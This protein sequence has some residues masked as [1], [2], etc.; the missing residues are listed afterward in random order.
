MK[1]ENDWS[2]ESE[3]RNKK[4]ISSTSLWDGKS[5]DRWIFEG[6]G[7]YSIE[8]NGVMKLHTYARSDHWPESEVRS[9][10]EA[11]GK[12]TTFGS[13]I[14]HL[15]VSSL[16]LTKGNRISF[17]IRPDCEGAHSTIVRVG[18]VNDGMIKIPDPYARE[19][20]NAMNLKNHEWNTCTW[21]IDSIA[22]D[23][24]T[25]ISFNCHRYGKE[26]SGGDNLY[27][28]IKDIC[29]D[30]VKPAVVHGWQCEGGTVSY[31]TSGYTASG[32]KTAVV[33]TSTETFSLVSEADGKTVYTGKVQNKELPAGK[34]QYIDFSDFCKEGTY[35]LQVGDFKT[36]PF[37]ISGNVFESSL[38]KMIN[39]LYSERCGYPVPN[40]H[41]T[42]HLDVTAEHNGKRILFAGGWHDAA[43]VSQQTVQTAEVCEGLM[44]AAQAVKGKNK[45]L[46]LRLLEEANYGL[47]FVLRSRFGD[48][49]RAANCSI[50]RWTNLET[51]DMDDETASVNNRSFENFIFAA[52]EA[53]AADAFSERDP[54]LCFKLRQTAAEDF[55]FAKERLVSYGL[56]DFLVEQHTSSASISQYYAA[57]ALAAARLVKIGEKSFD[58]DAVHFA[59]LVC[60]CQ[61]TDESREFYG[62]FYRDEKKECIVHFTHQA[63][64]QIFAQALTEVCGVI[65]DTNALKR[66]DK[67]IRLHAAYFKKLFSYSTPYGMLPSGIYHISELDREEDFIRI[68][69]HVVFEEEKENYRKQ[70]QNGIKLGNGYYLRM[71]PVW[72]SF[73]GNN[74]VVLSMGKAASALG[75]YLKD[76]ELLD[77]G[78]EQLYWVL[79][80]NPFRQSLIFGEGSR[81][82]RNYTALLC[83]TTGEIPVGVQT[84]RNEDLPYWP[85]GA[86]ATYR[87]I[88]TTPAGKWLNLAADYMD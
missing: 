53:L 81:Y 55:Q 65:S 58:A 2:F 86:I 21:E 46:Y 6:E 35:F 39:F 82:G 34:F 26:V 22:H 79:G 11:S 48:G 47:D 37:E 88:W 31:S 8:E 61:E 52:V 51:P 24:I 33:S 54:E 49:Y 70:L 42:C 66:Y 57:A 41:G 87:E 12:Y 85:A 69:P 40:V 78:K 28:E 10:S 29:F 18:F 25:E 38:W 67:A 5:C 84:R 4:V 45:L 14:A 44:H 50:R 20:F 76:R 74:A 73:R 32:E 64:D 27:F 36:R 77:I 23:K 56:E 71:F 72:F 63:R 1:E 80:K 62:Y 83:E 59:D 19:G 3:A 13:Y 15:D 17:K 60:A 9:Y 68:H 16:H 7:D 30:L 43:D 75:I